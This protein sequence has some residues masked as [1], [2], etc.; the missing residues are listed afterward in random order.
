MYLG[1]GAAHHDHVPLAAQ[2]PAALAV[3]ARVTH[4][5][6][7]SVYWAAAALLQCPNHVPRLA[8]EDGLLADGL[9]PEVQLA[10]LRLLP[11]V[12]RHV[13]HPHRLHLPGGSTGQLNISQS[14]SSLLL[15]AKILH[16][17]K[18]M[19]YHFTYTQMLLF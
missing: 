1:H 12:L 4:L 8:A 13:H 15:N 11:A 7:R 9:G 2:L 14:L 18:N 10:V 16:L 19:L 3:Q 6:T 17:F 5:H